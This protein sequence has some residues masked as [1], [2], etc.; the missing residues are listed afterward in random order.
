MN[1]SS[2]PWEEQQNP[3]LSPVSVSQEVMDVLS[4]PGGGGG[5]CGSFYR[6]LSAPG[7]APLQEWHPFLEP[8][9]LSLGTNLL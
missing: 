5:G 9:T 1:L 8:Q 3:S 6:G 2:S 4:M 7:A